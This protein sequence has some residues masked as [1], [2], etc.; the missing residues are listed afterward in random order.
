M[1]LEAAGLLVFI[2][3]IS[4]TDTRKT[5]ELGLLP[6]FLCF[7]EQKISREE[8]LASCAVVFQSGR[9]LPPYAIAAK[10]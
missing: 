4:P 8:I 2:S 1:F 7:V 5:N 10:R 3:E 9:C 6:L